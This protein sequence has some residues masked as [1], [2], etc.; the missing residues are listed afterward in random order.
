[1][2]YKKLFKES[3]SSNYSNDELNILFSLVLEHVTKKRTHLFDSDDIHLN[4]EQAQYFHQ[5]IEQ[6]K[7]GIPFQHVLGEADFYGI[8]FIVDK[9]VLIPRPETEELVHLIIAEQKDKAIDILDIGTGSGCIAVILKHKLPLAKVS[10]L[11]ISN[12]ALDIAKEN[13]KKNLVEVLFYQ[14]DA[15]NMNSKDYPTYDIIVSNPPYIAEKEIAGMDNLVIENEP[16]LALFV[17]NNDALIFY[18][19]ISDFALTNLKPSG[20]LY[21]EINQNLALETKQL[22]EDKGFNALLIK[23][24]NDN[25]RMIKAQLRG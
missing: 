24:L 11:D 23:D 4:E 9:N 16:H 5:I 6:L 8:K 14:A 19:K 10:A 20:S 22:L 7:S 25:Y 3:L 13:A 17:S 15:L 18:D 12:S 2:N 1:M 21:F